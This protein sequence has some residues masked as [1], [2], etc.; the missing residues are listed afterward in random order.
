MNLNPEYETGSSDDTILPSADSNVSIPRD[1]VNAVWAHRS[2]RQ[3][4]QAEL[5]KRAGISR[6][7]VSAIE[8]ERLT[9]SVSAALAL[10]AALGCSVEELFG[11]KKSTGLST[12]EWAWQPAV[13]NARYWEA[14]VACR[15]LLFPV[16]AIA[17]NPVPHDGIWTEATS[18]NCDSKRAESTLIVATC[19]PAA[20]LI[21]AEYARASGFR[22]LVFPRG[23]WAA[24]Q[25]ARKGLVHVAAVHRSTIDHP[26]LN[27]ELARSELGGDCQLL[28][29]AQWQAGIVLPPGDMTR[30]ANTLVSQ[31]RRWAMREPGSAARECLEE[32]LEGKSCE[33]RQ[34]DG[35]FSVAE[36]V[37]AGWAEAGVCVKL[38]A[39]DA[40][41]NF[42][43]I[44]T[45]TLDFCFP[46]SQQ[47]DPR[48]L[49]LTTLLRSKTCRRMLG[50]LPGYNSRQTGE[51]PTL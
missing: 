32:L 29:V 42:L 10:A 2:A 12:T 27:T 23:G 22:M 49:A 17:L 31:R 51:I 7:A 19:D 18:L 3:W 36:A 41:L 39:V 45:E 1:S 11:R 37:R 14:Q 30:S 25:L 9:P 50:E 24:L 8:Q 48:I 33:G 20:G 46:A 26:E 35:H 5:A 13:S 47:H 43:P 16:E 34:V 6:A 28:R 44:R 21:A 4:S 38:C 40:G 15:H